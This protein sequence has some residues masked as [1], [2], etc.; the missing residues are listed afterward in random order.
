MEADGKLGD[1]AS[2]GPPIPPEIVQ[3]L[4]AQ[5]QE[6]LK[7]PGTEAQLLSFT[8]AF[9]NWWSG[10]YPPP[11]LLRGY[12]DVLPGSA[13]RI[14]KMAEEQ[15]RH[16]HHL[17]KTTVEGAGKRAHQGLWLGFVISLV[18]LGLG[19]AVILLGHEAAGATIMSVDVV[20]LAG[21]F[22][23]GR[24]EQRKEREEK[25]AQTRLPPGQPG[26]PASRSN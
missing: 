17:E 20:A 9:A 14:I 12:E 15:Q 2:A 6:A 24:R 18:V 23:Y 21:V 19:T 4:P 13:D 1:D 7:D 26:P 5:L 3:S 8:A 10:P 11:Q 22:V 25:H 16:R